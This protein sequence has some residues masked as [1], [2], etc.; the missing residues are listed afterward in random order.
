M[1]AFEVR[2]DDWT[3]TRIVAQSDTGVL[4]AGEVRLE[5]DR[6]ALTSNNISYAA[7]GD[8]LGYWRFF[9]AED[10]WGR[11]PAMGYANVVESAHDGVKVG[12]RVWGFFPMATELRIQAGQVSPHGFADV[13]AHREG[14]APVYA[15]FDKMPETEPHRE[16]LN[17]L[18]RGLFMTSWLVEDALFDQDFFGAE[19]CLITS[20]SSKTSLALAYSVQDRGALKTVG[21]TSASKIDYLEGLAC[22]D[23]VISYDDIGSLDASL[24]SVSVDMAGSKTVLSKLHHHFA[25]QMKYSCLIGATHHD[26]FG[27][28]ENMPGAKPEF[29]FAP[30]QIQKR[31]E[32]WGPAVLQGRI[33]ESL[34]AFQD[35]IDP[36]MNVVSRSGEKCLEQIFHKVREGRAQPEDAY[37]L[38][39]N[40]A[41]SG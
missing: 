20:A 37:I 24:A 41:E 38:S 25:D 39:L 30:S 7:S 15:R 31:S 5:V 2:K 36:H 19:Q 11:I 6:F 13:S 17:M 34:S 16:D 26:D 32:E 22:Y 8:M 1:K 27:Q 14:L 3:T 28:E 21:L 12:E 33:A 10:G 40:G 18:L 29:F 4:Q 23:Q 35:F 9:P